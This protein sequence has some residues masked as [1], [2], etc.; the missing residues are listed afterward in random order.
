L[1]SKVVVIITT[2]NIL[3]LSRWFH[4]IFI[5]TDFSLEVLLR[6]NWILEKF[7]LIVIS[8]NNCFFAYNRNTIRGHASVLIGI[9]NIEKQDE[10]TLRVIGDGD[11]KG[12]LSVDLICRGE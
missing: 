9:S 12:N 2:I 6:A 7:P 10:D 8:S 5:K 11:G 3:K 4:I 1:S